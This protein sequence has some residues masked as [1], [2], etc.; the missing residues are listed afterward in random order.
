MKGRFKAGIAVTLISS[1]IGLGF[2][3][4]SLLRQGLEQASLWATFLVLPL[5]VISTFAAVWALIAAARAGGDDQDPVKRSQARREPARSGVGVSGNIHQERT[6]GT[7]VAHTGA[8]DIVIEATE[9][10][11]R[12][13]ES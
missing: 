13:D 3:S 1:A 12:S 9:P 5:T 8:G 2:L 6:G 10:V 11:E 7:T 4:W